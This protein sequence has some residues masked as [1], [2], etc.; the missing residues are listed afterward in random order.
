M[1]NCTSSL[2]NASERSEINH[3]ESSIIP[4]DFKM[5]SQTLC[6][7]F[8]WAHAGLDH[9]KHG[10]KTPHYE[11]WVYCVLFTFASLIQKNVKSMRPFRPSYVSTII[12]YVLCLSPTYSTQGVKSAW[13]LR[14]DFGHFTQQ[15]KGMVLTKGSQHP[16]EH[17]PL[18]GIHHSPLPRDCCSRQKSYLA[19]KRGRNELLK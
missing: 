6:N 15:V 19:R 17:T 12:S 13:I 5:G 9:C 7:L 2:P 4:T 10:E 18:V 8:H 3:M 16:D 14:C 1:E 11:E